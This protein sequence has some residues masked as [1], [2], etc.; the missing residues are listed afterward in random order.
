[1][2]KNIYIFYIQVYA[3]CRR[4]TLFIY[5]NVYLFLRET[6]TETELERRRARERGRH[7]I[8]SG[9]Q[10]PSR[11]PRARRGARTHGPRDRDLSR[12]RPLNRLS[13]PGA[14]RRLTLDP[15]TQIRC[16]Q[17]DGKTYSVQRATQKT[18]RVSMLI[19]DQIDLK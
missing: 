11:R 13:H 5:F 6:K 1:M 14:P 3:A 9:P 16:K 17:R 8:G 2:A 10:A 15:K 19:L 12:S 4:L 7:R 18:A